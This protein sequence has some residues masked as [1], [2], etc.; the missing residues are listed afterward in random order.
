MGKDVINKLALTTTIPA[1]SALQKN[2]WFGQLLKMVLTASGVKYHIAD[3]GYVCLGSFFGGLIIQWGRLSSIE[4]FTKASISLPLT[5]PDKRVTVL[6]SPEATT[7]DGR[8][9]PISAQGFNDHIE[10]NL[11]TSLSINWCTICH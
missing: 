2:S 7:S 10:I 9:S 1:I 6:V 8:V 3:N 11:G 5:V 4:G